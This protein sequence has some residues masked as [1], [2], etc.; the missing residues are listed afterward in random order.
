M[1]LVPEDVRRALGVL[2]ESGAVYELRMFGVSGMGVVAGFFDDLDALAE[3]ACEYDG[4]AKSICVTV[5]PVDR[6]LLAR[7]QHPLNALAEKLKD[8]LTSDGDVVR[9]R[10][11]FLD[12][13]PRRPA[14]V[15]SSDAEKAAATARAIAC[16]AWFEEL[17]FPP[18]SM[19]LADSGNGAHL[20]VR[21]DLPN[22]AASLDLVN[23]C[24]HAAA[25]RFDDE[26]VAVDTVV[27]N[28]GRVLK[29]YGTLA[30]KGESTPERPHRRSSLLLMPVSGPPVATASV[31]ALHRLAAT[32]PPDEP[33]NREAGEGL[34]VE[35]WIARHADALPPVV[36]IDGWHGGRRWNLAHCPFEPE[37][38]RS[39]AP[40][41]LRK[42]DGTKAFKCFGARCAG[43]DWRALRALVEGE[44][45]PSPK[46]ARFQLISDDE[47]ENQLPPEWLVDGIVTVGAEVK[48][49]GDSAAGKSFVALDLALCIATGH[50]W[51][52]RYPVKRGPVVY[53]LAEGAG[54]FPSRVRAWKVA[55]DVDGAAGLMLLPH[56]VQLAGR[57]APDVGKLLAAIRDLPEPPV[58][59]VFDTQNRCAEGF[60]E[61]SAKDMSLLLAAVARLREETGAGV[62]LVHHT[63]WDGDRERGHSSQRGAVETVI[64]V[65]RRGS[66]Q[67]GG[68]VTLT[69][70]KQKDAPEFD[71]IT[72]RARVVPLDAGET[73]LVLTAGEA[74][75]ERPEETDMPE[76]E[77]EYRETI[78]RFV[79]FVC[80]GPV[81]AEE[82]RRQT[83]IPNTP[84]Y[85]VLPKLVAEGRIASV[86]TARKPRYA[87]RPAM[88]AA[89]DQLRAR[90]A[91]GDD[92]LH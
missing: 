22:D 39:Y 61:N 73:S 69:C 43:N 53:V 78:E 51:L 84:F 74:P 90:R 58:A 65:E 30:C 50:P 26:V 21:T 64:R 63:G 3:A 82:L 80:E 2:C 76:K 12:F 75:D 40:A 66:L 24:L 15:S 4:R 92:L 55:H 85:R 79:A 6:A 42:A 67:A 37:H 1:E 68:T 16:R 48:I 28:A 45:P 54:G 71:R 9:R 10:W 25:L 20:L 23:H 7:H 83:G 13:D 87:P 33:E 11:V 5:N 32:L 34:N 72:A 88:R 86:G 38:D 29:L 81:G 52:G 77:T 59:I 14:K 46:R 47:F 56:A 70:L 17:G 60:D 62:W 27:G 18:E 49:V 89:L 91:A 8:A 44:A 31:E 19:V 57:G 41:I 36:S 35:A